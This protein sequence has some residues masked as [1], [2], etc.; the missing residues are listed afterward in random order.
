MDFDRFGL[1]ESLLTAIKALG[2]VQPTP[3][4]EKVIPKVLLGSDIAAL[5]PTGTGKSAAFLLPLMERVIRSRKHDS[6]NQSGVFSGWSEHHYIL[7]LV[8]TRELADQLYD[9][10]NELK[11]ASQLRAMIIHGGKDYKEQKDLLKSGIDFVFA[12]PGRTIDLFNQHAIDFR[13]VRAVVF[14]EADRMF[15]MGFKADMTFILHK[16]PRNRQFLV[17]SATLNYDALYVGYQ[18]GADPIEIKDGQ[19]SAKAE[20]V[21]DSIF[22]IGET[23]KPQFLL[24]LLNKNQ[25]VQ[26]IVFSNYKNNVER[27]AYF[28]RKNNWPSISIS[29][30]L[31]QSR[32][33]DVM[34]EFRSC[35]KAILV[36]TDLAARGLDVSGVDL[37]VNYD[38][39]MD[40]ENYVHRIGR[41]GRAGN[42]GTAIALVSEEDVDS[43][44]RIEDY[45]QSKIEIGWMDDVD[46]VSDFVHLSRDLGHR[47]SLSVLKD[48]KRRPTKK[49]SDRKRPNREDERPRST[50]KSKESQHRDRM[51]GRHSDRRLESKEE[52]RRNQENRN[53]VDRKSSDRRSTMSGKEFKPYNQSKKKR[54]PY[55]RPELKSASNQ[56]TPLSV[57]HKKESLF[58]KVS[59]TVK[60][61]FK[62]N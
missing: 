31:S 44:V 49:W 3:I 57:S 17:F 32:R 29:S 47:K 56:R 58:G 48:K 34:E 33:D 60:S 1:S 4:Q 61:W 40:P 24:S 51:T 19:D 39:P 55:K 28:L 53:S 42:M 54:T 9:Q 6:E 14:D 43:L 15:D 13:S 36:A 22:H 11:G 18:F 12:T 45:L 20:N 16:I 38:L 50:E 8:P 2:F 46:L 41:T 59:S 25:P 5:A 21:K 7:I 37:V 10:F 27:L 35:K 62:S 23:D 30:L 52:N 26:A